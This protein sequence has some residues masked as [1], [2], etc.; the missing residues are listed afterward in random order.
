[1]NNYPQKEKYNS[2]VKELKNWDGNMKGDGNQGL[3]FEMLR[4][5]SIKEAKQFAKNRLQVKQEPSLQNFLKYLND[6]KY[7]LPGGDD[8]QKI[9]DAIFKRTLDTL[10]QSYGDQWKKV[11]YKKISK[12]DINNMMFIPGLGEKIDNIGG[13]VNTINI[14]TEKFHP[15]FRAVYEVKNG[16]IQAH[17]ILAGGQ[18]GLIN[19]T[20][21]KDQ[22]ESWRKGEYKKSQFVANPA[23]LEKI[24]T[25]IKF[26]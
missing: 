15:V 7:T 1:M 21:Y 12:F 26:N 16:N 3:V 14:N 4:K 2:I 25:T 10:T 18:S 17:T 5:V 22:I 11:T 19:S 20:H 9:V 24:I 13:N 8:K 23:K 6:K